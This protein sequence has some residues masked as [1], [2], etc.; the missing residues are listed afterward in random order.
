MLLYNH[1][2]AQICLSVDIVFQMND[3]AYDALVR[4]DN[5]TQF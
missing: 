2:S 4:Q 5:F 1:V 3:M